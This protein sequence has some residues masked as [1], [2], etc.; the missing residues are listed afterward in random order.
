MGEKA[1]LEIAQSLDAGRKPAGIAGTCERLTEQEVASRNL[2]G[3][4]HLI[5]S[6]DEIGGERRLFLEA[7][8]TIDRHSRALSQTPLLQKQQA[9][10]V[11]QHPPAP[12]LLT[13][14]MDRLYELPYCR[15]PHPTAVDIPAWRMIRHSV[16]I[17][18]GCSGNC[19][20]CAIAR[21]QGPVV[22]SRSPA[23]ILAEVKKVAALPDFTGTISDLGGPTANLYGTSC[24]KQGPCRRRDCLFPGVCRHLR[25]DEDLFC[26][27]LERASSLPGVRHIFVS[28]GM[29]ME[30]LLR[31]QKLLEKL[32]LHHTPGTMK[33][34]PEHTESRIL[35]L[36]TSPAPG[37]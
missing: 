7:E 20:F 6:W 26:S 36:I 25:I 19:S 30:I 8:R 3:K 10:W 13:A 22:T 15:A 1:V 34:A 35:K 33:I 4:S 27:L 17:V 14:E 29:R 31:T 28:S 21:H 12:P 16:T 32:I 9:M 2:T 37:S 11:L 5:P 18:R 24:G 23:S